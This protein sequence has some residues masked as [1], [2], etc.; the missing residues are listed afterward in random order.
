M[1]IYI[2]KY[3]IIAKSSFYKEVIYEECTVNTL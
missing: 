1:M 3:E 2:N